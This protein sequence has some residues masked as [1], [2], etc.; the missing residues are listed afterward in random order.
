[1]L[2]LILI[3]PYTA[4]FAPIEFGKVDTTLSCEFWILEIVIS[5]S[6]LLVNSMEKDVS[7]IRLMLPNGRL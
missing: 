5:L 7:S 4:D 6:E 2:V 3:V 1:M